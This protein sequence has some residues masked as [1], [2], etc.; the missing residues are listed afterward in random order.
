MEKSQGQERKSTRASEI[1]P[2]TETPD[3]PIPTREHAALWMELESIVESVP[4]RSDH[5]TASIYANPTMITQDLTS[6]TGWKHL[7]ISNLESKTALTDEK[8]DHDFSYDQESIRSSK[9]SISVASTIESDIVYPSTLRLLLVT[10]SLA[11][12]TFLVGLDRTIVATAT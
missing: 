11:I 2:T 1:R 4:N 5:D 3:S 12:A 9:R 8:R 6:S 7:S 10:V